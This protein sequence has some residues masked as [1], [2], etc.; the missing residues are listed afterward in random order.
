MRPI[1]KLNDDVHNTHTTQANA[2]CKR[3]EKA[4]ILLNYLD[5]NIRV[6][7]ELNPAAKGSPKFFTESGFIAFELCFKTFAT[8]EPALNEMKYRG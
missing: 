2:S 6:L 8:V 3:I 7:A 5:G 1:A 4:G